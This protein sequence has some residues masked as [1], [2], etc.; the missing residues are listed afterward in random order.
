MEIFLKNTFPF[1]WK[2]VLK[3]CWVL[4]WLILDSPLRCLWGVEF[5]LTQS[6]WLLEQACYIWLY[7][8]YKA[9]KKHLSICVSSCLSVW[10]I[11]PSVCNY[12]QLQNVLRFFMYTSIHADVVNVCTMCTNVLQM[13]AS[14]YK[15]MQVCT[16]Y[17]R[18][19]LVLQMC[20]KCI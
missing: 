1:H 18:D 10:L 9:Q 17:I 3:W 14:A 5:Q 8:N 6:G 11:L 16:K 19:T 4:G 2:L 15:F 12:T 13:Y 7:E 20:D